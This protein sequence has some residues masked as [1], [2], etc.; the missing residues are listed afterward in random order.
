MRMAGGQP[1][2]HSSR[3]SYFFQSFTEWNNRICKDVSHTKGFTSSHRKH[4]CS[5]GLMWLCLVLKSCLSYGN[6]C[7]ALHKY[8]DS[9]TFPVV[10]AL[11]QHIWLEI[12]QQMRLKCWFFNFEGVFTA[13]LI[14]LNTHCPLV[15]LLYLLISTPSNCTKANIRAHSHCFRSDPIS[16]WGCKAKT[17]TTTK[18]WNTASP[19]VYD[20][21]Y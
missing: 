14:A 21:H 16:L 8:L 10:L 1:V 17:T 18:E 5:F 20:L 15:N 13:G 4:I 6:I 19:S 12:K 11:V 7:G 9:D 2:S 3:P